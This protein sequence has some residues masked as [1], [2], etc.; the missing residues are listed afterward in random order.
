MPSCWSSRCSTATS[1]ACIPCSMALCLL[2]LVSS[3]NDLSPKSSAPNR[4]AQSISSCA[5]AI[6]TPGKGGLFSNL[7]RCFM[8][9]LSTS[10]S[11]VCLLPFIEIVCS[12][13]RVLRTM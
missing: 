11:R 6:S 4:N 5:A 13:V 7:S 10:W 8:H 12:A 2:V 9:L 1:D 3:W